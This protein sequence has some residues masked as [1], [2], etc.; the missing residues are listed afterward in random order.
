MLGRFLFA[1]LE[2][3]ELRCRTLVA[4]AVLI[5]LDE[6]LEEFHHPVQLGPYFAASDAEARDDAFNIL[7]AFVRLHDEPLSQSVPFVDD[8]LTFDASHLDGGLGGS[9]GGDQCLLERRFALAEGV[10]LLLHVV[11]LLLQLGTFSEQSFDDASQFGEV[12]VDLHRCVSLKTF[13]K[14]LA[15]DVHGSELGHDALLS[16][17]PLWHEE[18]S[19]WMIRGREDE[20]DVVRVTS[21]PPGIISTTLSQRCGRAMHGGY[22]TQRP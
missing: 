15:E 10:E 20:C 16:N 21:I 7:G 4:F 19:F 2:G 9:L 14:P 12:L 5:V 1:A 6:A 22:S 13:G 17:H 18:W 8:A 11:H 3:R